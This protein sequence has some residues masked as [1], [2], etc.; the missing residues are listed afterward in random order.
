MV[1]DSADLIFCQFAYYLQ[2]T[3]VIKKEL[4]IWDHQTLH[5]Y[6]GRHLLLFSQRE[7]Q[8]SRKILEYC[9]ESSMV[10][11][12]SKSHPAKIRIWIATTRTTNELRWKI[13]V[14]SANSPNQPPSYREV[15]SL[16][17][18]GFKVMHGIRGS[19]KEWSLGCVNSRP[20]ARGS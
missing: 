19:A 5:N 16:C 10:N 3:A 11:C 14:D 2:R 6:R 7:N 20:T 9:K 15:Q 18:L 4:W 17:R 8:P 13:S 1:S 12:K